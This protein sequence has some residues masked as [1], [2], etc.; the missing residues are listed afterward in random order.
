MDPTQPGNVPPPYPPQYPPYPPQY[1][2]AGFPPPP[3]Y[4]GPG[5][6]PA[7][8]YG[9][10]YAQPGFPPPLPLPPLPTNLFARMWDTATHPNVARF[11]QEL[12]GANWGTIWLVQAAIAIVTMLLELGYFSLASYLL[13]SQSMPPDLASIRQYLQFPYTLFPA[14]AIG[15]LSPI[16]FFIG[17]GVT[18]VLARMFGGKG[19]LLEQA[20]LYTLF[21]VPITIVSLVAG[22]ISAI[23]IVGLFV[24]A[25][26]LAV[27]VYQ[28]I[29]AVNAVAASHRIAIGRA[30]AVVLLPVAIVLLLVCAGVIA[31]IAVASQAARSSGSLS[32]AIMTLASHMAGWLGGIL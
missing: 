21:L 26:G 3:G 10:P 13:T 29:L 6:P 31:L 30:V 11:T 16:G 28:I 1:P 25:A 20:W 27:A 32:P 2:P 18:W 5:Y 17:Q 12:E 19:T 23:P 4:A 22:L 7:P 8:P 9:A 15:I 14:V 24:G